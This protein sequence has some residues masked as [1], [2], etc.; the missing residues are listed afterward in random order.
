M[1]SLPPRNKKLSMSKGEVIHLDMSL[2]RYFCLINPSIIKT[3]LK[4]PSVDSQYIHCGR[5]P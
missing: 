1:P 4:L 3:L 2:L 5:N